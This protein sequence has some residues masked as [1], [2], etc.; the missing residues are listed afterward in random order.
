M[1]VHSSKFGFK[2]QFLVL[3]LLLSLFCMFGKGFAAQGA[4]NIQSSAVN[5]LLQG[6]TAVDREAFA[7][8]L[9][10]Q[11]PLT[12]PQIHQLHEKF[13]SSRRAVAAPVGTLPRPTSKTDL[14]SLAPGATPPVIRLQAGFVS[15]VIFLDSTGQPWPI[16][17]YDNGNPNAFNI[18]WDEKSNPSTLLIQSQGDYTPANLVV[19]LKGLNTPVVLTLLT[20]QAA[21]DYRVDLR[22]PGRGPNA[23]IVYGGLPNQA[24]P[25]LMDVLDGA[26]P[27]GAKKLR[28]RGGVADAWLIGGHLFVRTSYTLLSP[29]WVSTMSSSDGTHAYELLPVPVLLVSQQG[30][31]IQLN[32]EGL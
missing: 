15:T 16:E 28:V 12:T 13:D 2:K 17:A 18:N 24:N 19:M 9:K 22:V 25:K 11:I 29:S 4:K 20:G 5:T 32:V 14:V 23:A 7:S 31:T 26:P 27:Y 3:S 6:T 30:R 8:L 10:S 21:V 1:T